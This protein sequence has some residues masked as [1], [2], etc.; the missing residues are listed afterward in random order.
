MSGS[1]IGKTIFVSAAAPATNNAAGF[2]A[3]TWTK[4]NGLQSAPQLG[5]SHA[6]IDVPDL[7]TGFVSGV[8][9]AGT[10]NDS[11]AAFR[12]VPADAGQ[13]IVRTAANA[14]GDAGTLSIK[15]VKGSGAAQAPVTGDPVQYATGYAHSYIENQPTDTTFE[16]FSV[17]FKQAA[18][19]VDATQ[20]A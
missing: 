10:G 1:H 17:N 13:V 11:T 20:P 14:G 8:K 12:M 4:V 9:G 18:V 16:G 5:V 7:Q 19:T 15:I 6:N 3:L 2:A